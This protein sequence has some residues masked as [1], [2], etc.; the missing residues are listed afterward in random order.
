MAMTRR[1]EV[2]QVFVQYGNFSEPVALPQLIVAD[3]WT[4][5]AE[6]I[7][8]F[9]REMASKAKGAPPFAYLKLFSSTALIMA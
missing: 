8:A 1:G 3:L 5:S 6:T 4:N 9:G 7:V 2:F